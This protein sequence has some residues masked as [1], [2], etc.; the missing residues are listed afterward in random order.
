MTENMVTR[1][2]L[3]RSNSFNQ[4]LKFIM[5]MLVDQYKPAL[6]HTI[7]PASLWKFMLV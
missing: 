4:K 3:S 5:P 6:S 2:F 7:Q 1:K